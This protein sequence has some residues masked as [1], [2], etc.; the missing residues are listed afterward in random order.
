MFSRDVKRAI[1]AW[2]RAAKGGEGGMGGAHDLRAATHPWRPCQKP[3]GFI[4]LL[5][6][7]SWPSLI[8]A[9]HKET[10]TDPFASHE[11]S[12]KTS[13]TDKNEAAITTGRQEFLA[14]ICI[15]Q[16]LRFKKQSESYRYPRNLFERFGSV[17]SE[18]SYLPTVRKHPTNMP[19]LWTALWLSKRKG[20][21]LVFLC[22][23]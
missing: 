1:A 13:T 7:D 4:K 6:G 9:K 14:S 19:Q 20:S 8:A 17:E 15:I 18:N 23:S 21:V 10:R 22:P 2:V 12:I 5:M 3:A 16:R 11:I